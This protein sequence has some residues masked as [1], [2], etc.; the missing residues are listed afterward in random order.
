MNRPDAVSISRRR[1]LAGTAAVS[2]ASLFM[3][4]SP[5]RAE[6]PP[7]VSRIRIVRT[8]ALC[9]APQF[10]A[11]ELLRL[12]GFGEVEYVR[13]EGASIPATLVKSADLA[14][15]GG[16]SLLPPIDAGLPIVTLC[17]IHA[18]CWEFFANERIYAIRDLK[19]KTVAIIEIGGV[20]HVWIASILAYLGMDPRT[21]IHWLP[22]GKMSETPRLF[23]EGKADAFLAFP[24]QPQEL[25]AKK[26]GRVIVNTTVD[27]PYS[28]YFCC[29]LAGRRDF[30]SAHPVATKRA[31]RA[32]LRATDI[33]AQDPERAARFLVERG[34]DSRYEIALEIVKGL[35]Y[36]RWR[37][38]DPA[39][40]LRFH[41]L[42][43][44]DV[45]MIKTHPNKLI[46]QGMDLRFLNEL[47]RELK[48]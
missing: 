22:S 13:T 4:S 15:F 41:G 11:E 38:S 44:Y 36:D 1:F 9:F 18:G 31:L 46:A 39:D 20:D 19:G 40:T 8:P 29:M 42:R 25:R 5:A 23:L 24:P 47:K 10:L 17:G 14:M 35:P 30:V 37:T 26:I 16:P 7:E 2:A 43:L 33:C 21:D 3:Q 12:E 45:G 28:Q 34:Y 48:A 27:R 32:M 6:P